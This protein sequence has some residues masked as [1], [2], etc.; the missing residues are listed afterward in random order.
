MSAALVRGVQTLAGVAFIALAL[1]WLGPQL[2]R[3]RTYG[4]YGYTP[5]AAGEVAQTEAIARTRCARHEFDN[6]SY[7]A[8]ADG[9]IVCTD[10]RGRPHPS[11]KHP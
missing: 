11:P 9:G 2:D 10:K 6:T 1:G 7:I 5:E 4:S 3:E 8:T